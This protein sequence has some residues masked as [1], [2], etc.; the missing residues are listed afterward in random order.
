MVLSVIAFHCLAVSSLG[1]SGGCGGGGWRRREGVICASPQGPVCRRDLA[2]DP[3][4][5]FSVFG[6]CVRALRSR[7]G[8]FWHDIVVFRRDW[9]LEDLRF[10][11]T[12]SSDLTWC[13]PPAFHPVI[14]VSRLVGGLVDEQFRKA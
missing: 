10:I 4:M 6:A 1:L 14:P 3:D 5:S 2:R 8:A 12:A 9:I 11:Q 7:L 13:H